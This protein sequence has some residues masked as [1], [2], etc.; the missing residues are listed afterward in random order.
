MGS[1]PGRCAGII[2][3]KG[4]EGSNA[5][6]KEVD[7]QLQTPTAA[8]TNRGGLPLLLMTDQEGGLVRRLDGPPD[9]SAK[10]MGQSAHPQRTTTAEG[11]AT[12]T[13]MHGRG[14]N[15]NLAPVLDVFRTPGNFID[16]FGR[17]FSNNPVTV[18][19][20]GQLF[21]S[22]MQN[23][24]VAATV[25]HF[26]GLG[27]ATRTQNTDLR[28]VTLNLTLNQ[29]RSIDEL[30]YKSAISAKVKLAM[31]SWA[32]YPAPDKKLPTALSTTVV[33]ADL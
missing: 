25:K 2:F 1:R 4:Y 27:A 8:W 18:A 10:Q 19:K 23:K 26:P 9:L 29:I 21:L 33:H 12:G 14:V 32:L 13:F 31:V 16:Q 17:S 22:A 24:G 7:C 6:T 28:P 20:L 3:M 15:V 30:P 5:H 11:Q